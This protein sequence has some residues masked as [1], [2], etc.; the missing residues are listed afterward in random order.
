MRLNALSQI[1]ITV[2]GLIAILG[3]VFFFI[4]FPIF[5]E[6]KENGNQWV[7]EQKQLL[8][9]GRS[10]QEVDKLAGEV[11]RI[12]EIDPL[13]Q[14]TLIKSEET[15]A[16]IVALENIGKA[17]RVNYDIGIG[18]TV[19]LGRGVSAT[20]FQISLNG[21][22]ISVARFIESIETMPQYAQIHNVSISR[23]GNEVSAS[24]NISAFVKQ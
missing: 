10:E 22:F 1:F 2:S 7:E 23:R 9:F 13:A 12:M 20:G 24:L 15:I 3:L 17:L 16:F 19:P 18:T 21:P 8:S 14:Q 6:V 11:M 4:V 5:N